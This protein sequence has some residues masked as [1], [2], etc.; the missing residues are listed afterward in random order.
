MPGCCESGGS[1][2]GMLPRAMAIVLIATLA[3]ALHSWRTPVS[4]RLEDTS[5]SALPAKPA[6]AASQAKLPDAV[7]SAQPAS[8]TASKPASTPPSKPGAIDVD[9]L[10]AHITLEQAKALYDQGIA[11][12]DAR[13]DHEREEGWITGSV[14]LTAAMM[15]GPKLPDEFD[16]LDREAA[17]IIYCAGGTCDASE[18]LAILLKQAGFAKLHIFHDGFPAW[19]AA[20]FPIEG[21]K[22]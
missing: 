15:S 5:K 3:G 18:N 9:A 2:C 10:P 14:H 22:K 17:T 6:D 20:G 16:L 21:G 4:L 12:V 11:F 7:P 13:E 1:C 19:K 8:T